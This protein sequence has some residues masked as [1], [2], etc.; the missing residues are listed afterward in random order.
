[1][2]NIKKIFLVLSIFLLQLNACTLIDLYEKTINFSTHEWVSTQKPEFD[3]TI[4]DTAFFYSPFLVVRHKGE[5]NFNN[6]WLKISIKP[7]ND[8]L[9]IFRFEKTLATNEKGWLASGLNDIYEHRIPMVFPNFRVQKPGNYKVVVEQI[10]REDTLRNLIS[11]GFRI[12][13]N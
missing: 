8:S 4:S 3:F 5:Y 12:E 7:P 10:M 6:I 2:L 1:M 13:K 11:I 9:Q